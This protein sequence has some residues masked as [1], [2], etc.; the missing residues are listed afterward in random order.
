MGPDVSK[1]G[2]VENAGHSGDNWPVSPERMLREGPGGGCLWE[3][4]A[5]AG[6]GAVGGA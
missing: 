3:A 5:W 4:G 1:R 6:A 2:L